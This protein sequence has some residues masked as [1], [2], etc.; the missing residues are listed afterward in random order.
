M[1]V[2]IPGSGRKKGT[3]NK[4]NQEII[5]K[6]EELGV[7]PFEIILLFAKRDWKALGYKSETVIKAAKNGTYE[8][9][10]ITAQMQLSAAIEAAQYLYPKRKAIEHSSDPENPIDLNLKVDKDLMRDLV[11]VARDTSGPK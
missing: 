9:D 1:A 3:P 2:K 6:A 7:D 8:V 5:D 11:K 4:R 10:T